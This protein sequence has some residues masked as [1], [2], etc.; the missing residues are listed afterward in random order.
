MNLHAGNQNPT[1]QVSSS[2]KG[3]A[4]PQGYAE[5]FLIS[6]ALCDKRIV[7]IRCHTRLAEHELVDKGR[8]RRGLGA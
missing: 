2:P 4:V 3:Q 8:Y 5:Q 1:M 6:T 7:Y